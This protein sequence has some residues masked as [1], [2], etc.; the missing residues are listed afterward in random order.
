M[1]SSMSRSKTETAGHAFRLLSATLLLCFC[2]ACATR[3]VPFTG[4]IQAN[5]VSDSR[6]NKR[7]VLEYRKI[8]ESA[9]QPSETNHACRVQE[10][11]GRLVSAVESYFAEIGEMERLSE[12][13]WEF[14]VIEETKFNAMCLP[15]GKIIVHSGVFDVITTDDHLA[16]IIAHEIAHALAHHAGE[17]IT[18]AQT[19]QA[20]TGAIA[21]AGGTANQMGQLYGNLAQLGLLLPHSRYQEAEADHI[22]LIIM[23]MAGYDPKTA[24]DVWRRMM[25][26]YEG[27]RGPSFLGTHP[28]D[29]DR[30][31]QLDALVP[32]VMPI[33]EAVRRKI[34]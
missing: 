27:G 19:I 6:L 2:S 22:G 3:T 5:S 26:R 30:M 21:S 24:G 1:L 15:G 33:Y 11:A 7:A 14:N 25:E 32:T 13:S 28:A 23:S 9:S 10:V 16:A 29:K 31:R 8:L 12:F 17:R 34:R 18:D 4:R 20:M